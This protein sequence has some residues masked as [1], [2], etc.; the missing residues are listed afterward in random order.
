MKIQPYF[1][2]EIGVNHEGSVSLQKMIRQAKSA[3]M[4]AAKFQTYKAENLVIKKS[5]A[6]WD[7]KKE[8]TRS[9]FEL[10]KS[11]INLKEK[12]I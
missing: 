7:L 2:A 4:N 8:S 5:P 3:G 1:I 10:L 9:Q 6:Y 11:L 12:I